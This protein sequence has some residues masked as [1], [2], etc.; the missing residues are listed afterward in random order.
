MTEPGA[1]AREVAAGE[2][3]AFGENWSRFLRLVDDGRIDEAERSLRTMLRCERL[4][5]RRFLDVGCGSGL[6]SLAAHRLGA[7]VHS[8]DYDPSSVA[9]AVELRRRFGDAGPSWTIEQG[10]VLDED[11]MARFQGT[12]DVV[13]SWGVLHHTGSMWRAVTLALAA[14]APGGQC[15]LALYNRQPGLS[16]WWLSVK[17][18]YNALPRWLQ[19]VMVLPFYLWFVAVG[20]AADLLHGRNPLERFRGTGRR[21]MSMYRDVVDWVGGLPFEVASP[22]EVLVVARTHGLD[23]E[24]MRTVGGRHGCNEFV[25]RRLGGITRVA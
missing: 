17:K 12:Y 8:F 6:F 13:Y 1:Q 18:L 7:V 3:F 11:F 14:T 16:D 2:R 24:S 23:L 4:D 10:S 22:E 25:F 21:G 20:L 9:C 5:G 15:F 19:P